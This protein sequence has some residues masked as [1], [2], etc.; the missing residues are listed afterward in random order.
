M[1]K[2]LNTYGNEGML[3]VEICNQMNLLIVAIYLERQ[4]LLNK[5]ASL[6]GLLNI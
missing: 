3:F 5:K 6:F 2:K 1:L 4:Q